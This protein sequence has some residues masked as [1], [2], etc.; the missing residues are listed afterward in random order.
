MVTQ[1]NVTFGCLTVL[2]E[3]MIADDPICGAELTRAL[4]IS[5]GTVYPMLARLKICDWIELAGTLP[6]PSQ[7]DSHFYRITPKGRAHFLDMLCRL[8]IPSDMWRN[9]PNGVA[10][11]Y[12]KLRPAEEIETLRKENARYRETLETI[13]GHASDKLQAAQARG[14]LANIGAKT[15]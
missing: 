10:D 13:A 2:R 14:T 12:R 4:K 6:H 15:E 9:Q 7:P 3:M 5:S 1:M 11:E 8:T